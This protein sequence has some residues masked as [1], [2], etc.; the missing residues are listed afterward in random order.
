[1]NATL[2]GTATHDITVEDV[3]VQKQAGRPILA[4]L[5]RPRGAGPFPTLIDIHG[6]AWVR[7]DRMQNVEIDTALA[8]RGI[9][10]VAPDFRMP[11]EAPYPTSLADINL[12]IRWTKAHARDFA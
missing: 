4:R 5:Y 10:V 11:P 12:A 6:G 7:G 3:E 8:Q 2:E 1:M 9:L